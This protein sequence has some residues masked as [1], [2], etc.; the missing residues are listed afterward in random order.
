MDVRCHTLWIL[1][2]WRWA[3]VW[4]GLRAAATKKYD[5]APTRSD[6]V[7]MKNTNFLA[8]QYYGFVVC[9]NCEILSDQSNTM[10]N[11]KHHHLLICQNTLTFTE[12][13]FETRLPHIYMVSNKLF[14][15]F[16][17]SAHTCTQSHN[18][19]V[20]RKK[21]IKEFSFIFTHWHIVRSTF[22]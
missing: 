3:L 11:R 9:W 15:S 12:M 16:I 4:P 13:T 14:S 22:I 17:F 6:F 21:K 18:V 8:W 5:E 2:W 10:I 1:T 19:W 20:Q 7:L